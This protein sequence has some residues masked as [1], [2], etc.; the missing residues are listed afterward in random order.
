[1]HALAASHRIVSAR[2]VQYARRGKMHNYRYVLISSLALWMS[3]C[4]HD[5]EPPPASADADARGPSSPE[6]VPTDATTNAGP[7]TGGTISQAGD[8]PGAG[9]GGL[10]GSGGGVGR[11]A[12][13]GKK[14]APSTIGSSP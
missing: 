5:N 12:N 8:V 6:D 4:N 13:D 14:D 2:V 7:S 9:G 11:S 1:M 10:G 3:A